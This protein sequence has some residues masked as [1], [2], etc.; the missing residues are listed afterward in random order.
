M[1]TVSSRLQR[2]VQ[3][4]YLGVIEPLKIL[5]QIVSITQLSRV[6]K[7]FKFALT[8]ELIG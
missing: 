4:F 2:E 1:T 5:I 7:A 3:K 6:A 8:W